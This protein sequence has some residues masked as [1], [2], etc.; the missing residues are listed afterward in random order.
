ML[1][2]HRQLLADEVR[3]SAFRDAIAHVVRPGDVVLDIGPGTASLAFFACRAGARHVYAIE[4]QHMA[5]VAQTLARQLGYADRMTF[6]HARSNEVELPEPATVLIT[7]TL[8]SLGFDEGFLGTVEDARTRLLAP[9]AR[10]IPAEVSLWAA[11]AELPELHTRQVDWWRT[12]RFGFDFSPLRLFAANTVYLADVPPAALLAP[13]APVVTVD[14]AT[15]TGTSRRGDVTFRTERSGVIHGFALGFT[16]TLAPGLTVSNAWHG[17]DSWARGFLPL[18]EPANMEA[19]ATVS[20]SLETGN[21]SRWRWSGT[22]ES[23]RHLA[24]DQNTILSRPPCSLA[25]QPL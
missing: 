4:G 19:C 15:L 16:A 3:T 20:L 5:D 23:D 2:F 8:G 6:F 14:T 17:A 12:P 7:E 25:K 9:G 1:E 24:F 22:I 21:G 11:P 13:V 18:E 10:I